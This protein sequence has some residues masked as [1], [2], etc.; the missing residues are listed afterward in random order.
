[1]S[2]NQSFTGRN[3][4]PGITTAVETFENEFVYGPYEAQYISGIVIDA[5]ARDLLFQERSEVG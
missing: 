2:F 1:M 4:I 3:K 5:S